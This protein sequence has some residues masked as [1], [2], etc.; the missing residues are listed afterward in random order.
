MR[1]VVEL[2]PL[3][4]LKKGVQL[5][6][7][8]FLNNVKGHNGATYNKYGGLC[9]ETQNYTDSVNNQVRWIISFRSI[10]LLLLL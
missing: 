4:R 7:G 6:T 2:L 1:K 9:L 8:N 3:N 10:S 5:Y